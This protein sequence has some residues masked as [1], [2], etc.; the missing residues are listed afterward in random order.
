MCR[1]N[2][3]DGL[4]PLLRGTKHAIPRL[5][6]LSTFEYFLWRKWWDNSSECLSWRD[7]GT[8]LRTWRVSPP[9]MEKWSPDSCV[10]LFCAQMER[11]SEF[12]LLSCV[13]CFILAVQFP[14]CVSLIVLFEVVYDFHLCLLTFLGLFKPRPLYILCQIFFVTLLIGTF[15]LE[16]LPWSLPDLFVWFSLVLVHLGSSVFSAEIFWDFSQT[17]E[18]KLLIN[19][20]K[21]S[22][23][24]DPREE[25]LEHWS[26]INFIDELPLL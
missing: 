1:E 6:S 7:G 11:N 14:G 13:S 12:I 24:G 22:S 25:V 5:H 26:L 2:D 21:S 19:L 23:W 18:S 17:S 9:H 16:L 15:C 8:H 3:L 20:L 4:Q 10:A